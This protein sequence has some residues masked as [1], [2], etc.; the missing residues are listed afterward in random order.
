[1]RTLRL[2][3]VGAVVLALLGGLSAMVAARSE[4]ASEA[5]QAVVV[6]GTLECLDEPT[7]GESI[8][9][10]VHAWQAS[11]P[12]LSGDV[13]YTGSWRLY[14]PPAEEG[15]VAGTAGEAIYEIVNDGGDWL[16]EATRA[17][18]PRSP[19]DTH[20]V[21]F[22]GEG[23]YEGLTAYLSIDWSQSPYTFSGLILPGEAPPYAEPGG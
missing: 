11:D 12:R 4:E 23:G 21:V 2:S 7:D 19:T 16:C 22:T 17:P 14:E 8:D 20:T 10:N 6:S 1:M 3:L 5:E 18:G 13:T 15:D 9:V